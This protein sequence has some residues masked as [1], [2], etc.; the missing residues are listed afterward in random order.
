M[1]ILPVRTSHEEQRNWTF[2]QFVDKPQREARFVKAYDRQSQHFDIYL[3]FLVLVFSMS[4]NES[5]SSGPEDINSDIEN[6][7]GLAPNSQT[8]YQNWDYLLNISRDRS[9]FYARQRNRTTRLRHLRDRARWKSAA[10]LNEIRALQDVDTARLIVLRE[11]LAEVQDDGDPEAIEAI[12][13]GGMEPEVIDRPLILPGQTRRVSRHGHAMLKW[14][15]LT[16]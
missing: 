6:R 9:R 7:V 10:R 1:K 14:T 8:M 13:R 3:E 5:V 4:D 11:A 2:E 12:L 16:S 15:R